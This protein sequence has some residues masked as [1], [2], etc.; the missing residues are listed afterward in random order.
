MGATTNE[1][2]NWSG[3]LVILGDLPTDILT[4]RW[5]L[6]TTPHFV[7]SPRGL[8][9]PCGSLP[10]S[11]DFEPCER[12]WASMTILTATG[13]ARSQDRFPVYDP[14]SSRLNMRKIITHRWRMARPRWRRPAPVTAG[15]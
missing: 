15:R 8:V 1:A 5:H 6:G 4:F 7:L 2:E 3:H 9:I 12:R 11:T 10:Q 14:A 13:I